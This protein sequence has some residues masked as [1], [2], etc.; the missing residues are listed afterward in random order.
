MIRL[1]VYTAAVIYIVKK[2]QVSYPFW[3]NIVYLTATLILV[4][5]KTINLWYLKKNIWKWVGQEFLKCIFS[6]SIIFFISCCCQVGL[7]AVII[8][9]VAIWLFYIYQL[10]LKSN[11]S[12]MKLYLKRYTILCYEDFTS[13]HT[14]IVL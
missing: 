10:N 3:F 12:S 6:Y 4:V 2:L 7:Q 9:G 11:Y 1:C 8:D 13:C 14:S 5:C